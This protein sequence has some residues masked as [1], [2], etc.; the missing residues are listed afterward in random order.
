M[1]EIQDC[2]QSRKPAAVKCARLLGGDV[3]EP[4]LR[5]PFEA[6]QD[7]VRVNQRDPDVGGD[8]GE[9][10]AAVDLDAPTF[11]ALTD[12]SPA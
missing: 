5:E 3:L 1:S 8:R 9:R 4:F 2:G 12:E 11:L 6:V 7:F 10:L